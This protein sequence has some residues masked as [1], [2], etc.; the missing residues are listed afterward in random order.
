MKT[1]KETVSS[2]AL[3][4]LLGAYPPTTPFR[5][6]AYYDKHLDCIRIQVKDCS[7]TERRLNSF[8]TLWIEN[9]VTSEKTVG[10]TIKGVKH[11]FVTL[12]LPQSGPVYVAQ[13]IDG[14]LQ[15]YPEENMK[16][17]IGEIKRKFKKVLDLQVSELPEP[18]VA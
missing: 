2:E 9:H 5:P 13:I 12:G 18:E 10:F 7:F 3:Q 14:I 1:N 6:L 16:D 11:L 8:F 4:Q 15:Y 17:V